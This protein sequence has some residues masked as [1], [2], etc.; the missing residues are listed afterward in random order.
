MLVQGAKGVSATL[1]RDEPVERTGHM[2]TRR[3]VQIRLVQ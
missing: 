2:N 3:F 1:D